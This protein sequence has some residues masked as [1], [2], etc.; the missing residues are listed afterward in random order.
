MSVDGQHLQSNST[1][2]EATT[3][4]YTKVHADTEYLKVHTPNSLL[5]TFNHVLEGVSLV[6]AQ[7]L[8]V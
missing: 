3:I 8:A 2:R 5:N 7:F 4:V 6:K 1:K